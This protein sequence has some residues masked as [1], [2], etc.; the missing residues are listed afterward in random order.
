[1][2][3]A[4]QFLLGVSKRAPSCKGSDEVEGLV[5]EIEEYRKTGGGAQ[6]GRLKEMEVIV[7]SLYGEL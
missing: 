6:D 4:G 3:E 5:S 7:T 1:M 2:S